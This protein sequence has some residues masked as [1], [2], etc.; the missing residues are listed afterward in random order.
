MLSPSG[1]P[2]SGG[3]RVRMRRVLTNVS[4]L[5][6]IHMAD[7]VVSLLVA[8]ASILISDYVTCGSLIP[9]R[10]LRTARSTWCESA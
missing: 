7:V 2:E 10:A 1:V 9:I 5:G 4:D 3:E 6:G 8:A